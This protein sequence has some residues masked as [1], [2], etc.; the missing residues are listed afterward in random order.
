MNPIIQQVDSVFIFIVAVSVFFLL[1]ITVAMIYFMF[2]YSAKRHPVSEN[3]TGS[4]TLEILWTVIPLI[5][6]L[7]MFFYGWDIFKNMRNVPPDAMVIKVTGRMW[8]W[9]FE[10][11]NKKKSDTLLYVPVGKPIKM[12]IY[13]MDVNHSFYLPQFRVKE[14]AIPGRMNYLWFNPTQ[15]GTFDIFCA[16]YCGMNHSYMLGHLI[17]MPQDKFYEWYNKVDSVKSPLLKDSTKSGTIKTDSLKTQINTTGSI[18][19][20]TKTTGNNKKDSLKTAPKDSIN[21]KEKK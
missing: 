16:E 1:L 6:T 3:I 8:Y 20:S 4:T 9:G 7:M 11:D 14:D 15:V 2:R 18:K 17:V 19:D 13:S 21:R 12:E 10:Y 5:L